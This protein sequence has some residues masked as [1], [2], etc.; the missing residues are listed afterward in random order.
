MCSIFFYNIVKTN[1]EIKHGNHY[2]HELINET[3]RSKIYYD[4]YYSDTSS[5]HFFT[6]NWYTIIVLLDQILVLNIE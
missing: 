4:R 6:N 1:T 2:Y 5:L 3:Y